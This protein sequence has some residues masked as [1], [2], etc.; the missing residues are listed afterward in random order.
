MD[1]RWQMVLDGLDHASAPFSKGTLVAF[2]QRVIA[3]QMDR[4][5][6]ERTLESAAASGAFGARQLRAALERSPLWGAGRVEDTSKLLGHALRKAVGVI[7]RPQGRGLLEAANEVGAPLVGGASLKAALDW[8]WD[9]PPARPPALTSVLD[10]LTAVDPWRDTQPA[11]VEA[12]PEVPARVAVAHQV[13]APDVTMAANGTPSLRQG[14]A[15]ERR[16]RVEDGERRH[17]RKRR[18]LLVD[19]YQRHVVR[20]L[21]SRLSIA[22]GGTPA[23]APE[24][25]V[26]EARATDLA[27]QQRA[28]TEWHRDR[29]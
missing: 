5:L 16:I 13:C 8:D 21:A 28:L 20:D 3:Q 17:G 19:G 7:A 24:A 29:A 6:L 9:E 12:A 18:S 23:K 27:G 25:S 4:R 26:P 10:A 1:R 22:V 11:S 2:R 14:V 15:D